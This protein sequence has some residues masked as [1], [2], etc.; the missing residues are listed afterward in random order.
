MADYSWERE[1]RRCAAAGRH[2]VDAGPVPGAHRG[3][4]PG[5]L[6]R[7]WHGAG[8]GVRCAGGGGG[9]DLLPVRS[10]AGP[11]ARHHQ[12]LRDARHGRSALRAATWSRPSASAPSR[13]THSASCTNSR[14][15]ET[16]DRQGRRA[17]AHRWWPRPAG[18]AR[19]QAPG[20]GRE[21]RADQR[22]LARRDRAPHRRH[23]RQRRG[24]RRRA[25][26]PAESAS[27]PGW[28]TETQIH[29]KQRPADGPHRPQPLATA[30]GLAARPGP[31]P[32]QRPGGRGGRAGGRRRGAGR[33]PAGHAQ[34]AGA[35]RGAGLGQ[36]FP[37][38]RGGVPGGR[39][40]CG[41]AGSRCPGA[42]GAAAPGAA[43]GQRLHA[44][45]GIFCRQDPGP[46]LAVGHAQQRDPHPR[47]C[48]AGRGRAGCRRRHHGAGGR[49]ARRW[50]GRH[51][52]GRQDHHARG[53]QHLAR[54][55]FQHRHEPARRR[56][57]GRRGLAG[58]QPPA[59]LRRAAGDR[60]GADVD[61]HLDVVQVPA[62]GRS[63]A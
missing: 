30:R 21:R 26:V 58:H 15:A 48:C 12:P 61:R 55:V 35:G 39:G 60:G 47:R 40:R 3:P 46:R 14:T 53:H 9:R 63:A 2:A 37:A 43:A 17:G 24:P 32:R 4:R 11:D 7:R 45:R 31:A 54:A 19:L 10:A 52:A 5:R 8:R 42:A 36:R 23:P 33:E 6:L 49:A 50:P 13:R 44:V 27:R 34:P 57:G 56:P 38:L 22:G 16:L 1:P 25:L 51:L 29:P 28:W 18:L 62:R 59:G 20:A 41:W